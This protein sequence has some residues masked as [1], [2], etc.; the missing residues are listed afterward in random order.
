MKIAVVG[1][2]GLV[3]TKMLRLLEEYRLTDIEL[4]PAASERSIGK[5]VA[6]AGKS[7]RMIS[8][9]D[10]IDACPDYA[11][12]SAGGSASR[13]YAP[14]FAQKGCTVVDNSSAWRMD[15]AVPLVV[16][17][18]N[19][20][21]VKDT[22]RIIANPNCST[23]QMVLA[24]APIHKAYGI[25]RLVISTYQSVSG[26]GIKGLTQLEYEERGEESPLKAYPHPIHHNV[27]PHGGDF[28]P[29]GYTTEEMKLVNETRKILNDGSIRVTATVVRV[30]VYG[31]HSEAV[32]VETRKPFDL[33][34]VRRLLEQMPGVRVQDD[35]ANN[36]YPLPIHAYEKNEV[37]VGRIRR[38][39]SVQ[40]GMNL[41][42]VSDNIRKGAA[43]NAVQIVAELIRR[44]G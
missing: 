15:P 43:T 40:N 10:A 25:D 5:E 33:Q 13:Q 28:E 18:V 7:Y 31:G 12:F 9:Q 8:V 37:F 34:D 41:W 4:F 14:L 20:D 1:A 29:N 11:I 3:G 22:D 19:I 26:S 36:I 17:E 16:P 27:L 39:E 35:V 38:D 32:N 42:I 23:I 21:A 24:L 44:R 30:P 2:T 6:F